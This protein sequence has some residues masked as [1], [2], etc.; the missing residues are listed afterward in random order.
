MTRIIRTLM[1][2][3][4]AGV[5]SACASGVKMAEMKSSLPTL[6]ADSGRIFFYRSNSMI[7]AAVQPSVKLNGAVV[8]DSKPGGFF[9]VDAKAGP[10]EVSTST[11]TEKRLTFELPAGETRYVR[12]KIGFGLLIGRV[13][14]ELVDNPTGEK[15]IEEC[16][17]IGP[18]AAKP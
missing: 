16:K 8:G 13:Y 14:P 6:A 18:A 7:G 2:L 5:L 1:L 3:A 11:E 4:L 10:M 17:Y 15:E 12:T 9:F